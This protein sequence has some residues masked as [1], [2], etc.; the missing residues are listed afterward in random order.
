MGAGW[1]PYL[2]GNQPGRCA[3]GQLR[4][5]GQFFGEGG[6]SFE[7]LHVVHRGDVRAARRPMNG[8]ATKSLP[9]A[10]TLEV[11]NRGDRLR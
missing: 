9:S 10:D 1:L 7:M 6:L 4:P 3:P 2:I 8:Y 11:V 5:A